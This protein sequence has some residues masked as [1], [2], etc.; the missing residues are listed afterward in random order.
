MTITSDRLAESLNIYLAAS[1]QKASFTL[2]DLNG[3]EIDRFTPEA[4]NTTYIWNP[5]I[6]SAGMYVLIYEDGEKKVEKK[7]VV[8]R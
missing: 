8:Q 2:F 5:E 1:P 4:G 7:V 3:S 6:R